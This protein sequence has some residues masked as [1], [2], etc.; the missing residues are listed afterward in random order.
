MDQKQQAVRLVN[1]NLDDLVTG[2]E[3]GGLI[4]KGMSRAEL[5]HQGASGVRQYLKRLEAAVKELAAY[6]QLSADTGH[7]GIL[8][9][10]GFELQ[11]GQ[12]LQELI[13]FT[14][15]QLGDFYGH[16]C[17]LF[18]QGHTQL[19]ADIFLYLSTLNPLVS[20]FWMALGRAEE[21]KE[22]YQ[23]AYLAYLAAL[24]ADPDNMWPVLD[25]VRCL[26]Q[27]GETAVAAEVLSKSIEI[28][29]TETKHAA[30]VQEARQQQQRL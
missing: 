7:I 22:D 11:E 30:F 23:G 26:V 19:A 15:E 24:D 29:G 17:N 28:A 25:L 20:L 16:G 9:D 10:E 1:K 6:F 13:G 3:E 8:Y 4:P 21:R 12:T 2:L 14:D 27:L 18:E 5:H